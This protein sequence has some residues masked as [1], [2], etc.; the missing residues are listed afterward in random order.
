[1]MVPKKSLILAGAALALFGA[2]ANAQSQAS[3]KVFSRYNKPLKSVSLDLAT[4]TITRGP[5]V[6]N[7]SAT[8]TVDFNNND[9]GGFVGADTGNGCC[10]W[11]DAAVKGFA[12]NGSDLMN[13]IVFAYCSAMAPVGSGGP[14]GSVKLGFYEGYTW[15]GGAPTTTVAAFTLT[16]LP[17][18]TASSS[19]FGG[20]R[21]FFIQVTFTTMVSFQD[22]PIGYSWKFLDSG[23]T[24]VVAGTW[25]FLSCVVSCSGAVQQVDAQGMTDILDEYC[26]PGNRLATFTFGTTSGSWT[27]MSMD[28]R[29]AT[30]FTATQVGYNASISPNGDTL[31]ANTAV[32]GGTW[33]ATLARS[34]VTVAGTYNV[35]VRPT[36]I[37][38]PN[39][40][41]APAPVQGRLLISGAVLGSL[42][43]AHNGTASTTAASAAIPTQFSLIC[44][45]YAAQA[46]AT[47]GGVKLTS[48]LEGTTGTN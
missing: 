20:F 24:G 6:N 19:F 26:P 12:G 25:P 11:F 40:V 34:P 33:T 3:G 7:R 48:A 27:S 21:C 43:G 38:L 45:H 28:V 46:T 36:R 37:A 29:E 9:L 32:V 15:F 41:G 16:G 13:N 22:G 17:A 1:M 14:G 31:S 5:A 42:N 47:G 23:T 8:T 18:N 2:S 39:G 44:V 30:D 35:K 10:E 4:G